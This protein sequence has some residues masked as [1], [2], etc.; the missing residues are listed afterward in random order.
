MGLDRTAVVIA[1]RAGAEALVILK[2]GEI[3]RSPGFP[4]T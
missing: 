4:A 2:S 3:A 1:L